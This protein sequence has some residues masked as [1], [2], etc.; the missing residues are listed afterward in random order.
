M[1][2]FIAKGN[3]DLHFFPKMFHKKVRITERPS[4]YSFDIKQKQ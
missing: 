2:D 1:S 4:T 3:N